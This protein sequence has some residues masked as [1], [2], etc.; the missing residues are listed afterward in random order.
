MTVILTGY[1]VLG[2]KIFNHC[3]KS[4]ETAINQKENSADVCFQDYPALVC[5]FYPSVSKVY[6]LLESKFFNQKDV[7]LS[8]ANYNHGS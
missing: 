1:W 2:L 4:I 7:G 5:L 3:R 8:F 6:K